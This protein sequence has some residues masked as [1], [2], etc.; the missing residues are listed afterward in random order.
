MARRN[1]QRN[2]KQH[3]VTSAYVALNMHIHGENG[4]IVAPKEYL[5]HRED[6]IDELRSDF[7]IKDQDAAAAVAVAALHAAPEDGGAGAGA[8]EDEDKEDEDE[9]DKDE[10]EDLDNE[11]VALVDEED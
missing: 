6:Q 2:R 4:N 10:L 9:K 11:E 5:L 1:N 7:A 8:A 3:Q